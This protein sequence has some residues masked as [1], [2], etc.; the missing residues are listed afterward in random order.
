[1]MIVI[2]TGV[3]SYQGRQHKG[4]QQQHSQ[5]HYVAVVL[6]NCYCWRASLLGKQEVLTPSPKI[7]RP[8]SNQPPHF[9]SRILDSEGNGPLVEYCADRVAEEIGA[10]WKRT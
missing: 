4:Q 6:R 7:H 1:M 10:L 2:M 5:L 9:M 8:V 3:C